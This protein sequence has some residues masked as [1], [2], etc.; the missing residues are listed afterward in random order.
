MCSKQKLRRPNLFTYIFQLGRKLLSLPTWPRVWR[1]L[2]LPRPPFLKGFLMLFTFPLYGK[3]S[4]I[5]HPATPGVLSHRAVEE[6]S[7]SLGHF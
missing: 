1:L 4:V 7:S 6:S 3:F 5:A 2:S